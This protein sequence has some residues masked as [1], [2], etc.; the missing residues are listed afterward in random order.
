M[1]E[2]LNNGIAPDTANSD[3]DIVADAIKTL[4]NLQGQ[5]ERTPHGFH[6]TLTWMTE[7]P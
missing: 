5:L 1:S 2:V 6:Y 3:F 7:N 4:G